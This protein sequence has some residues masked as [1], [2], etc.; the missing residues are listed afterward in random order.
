MHI[1][2]VYQFFQDE[3]QPGHSLSLKVVNRLSQKGNRVSVFRSDSGY[4]Q[5]TK[6]STPFSRRFLK[7][8]TTDGIEYVQTYSYAN[9]NKSKFHRLWSH[10]SYALSSSIGIILSKRPDVAIVSSPPLFSSFSSCFIYW[11][12]KVPYILEVR[13]LWPES[14]LELGV[15]RSKILLRIMYWME[16]FIYSKAS[17]IVSLTK[18]IRDSI[19]KRGW[20]HKRHFF[21]HCGVDF[22]KIYPDSETGQKTKEAMGLSGKKVVLYFGA[23]GISNNLDVLVE[24]AKSLEAISELK[25][26]FI[27]DGI[28]KSTLEKR[29]SDLGL[30]NVIIHPA[31]PKNL[32][33]HY[34]NIADICVVNLLDISLFSG[35]IPTKL[36]DYMACSKP[37]LCGV[38]GEAKEIVEETGCGYFFHPNN[39]DELTQNIKEMLSQEE[40]ALEMGR[41]GYEKARRDFSMNHMVEK[42]EEAIIDVMKVQRG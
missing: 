22:D 10:L 15:V 36:I 21:I 26:V 9:K 2:L 16:S 39:S 7:K 18:G 30:K 31:V 33:R 42:M 35:A 24:S 29:V 13:D 27:G 38:R 12:L 6:K 11:L 17:G 41:R 32:A 34:I 4:M 20:A 28:Y 3:N 5:C 25:I 1:A 8:Y 23:L 37:V 40:K 14:L 19:V